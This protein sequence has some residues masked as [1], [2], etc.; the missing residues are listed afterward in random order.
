MARYWALRSG[1]VL[2]CEDA[3]LLN[4]ANAGASR[5]DV[6]RACPGGTFKQGAWTLGRLVH[7]TL[8]TLEL[9]FSTSLSETG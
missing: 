5:D 2:R 6:D 7:E 4:R 1:G 8:P 3:T 9:I